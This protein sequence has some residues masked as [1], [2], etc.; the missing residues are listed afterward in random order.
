M[1]Y[2]QPLSTAV[3]PLRVPR[4]LLVEFERLGFSLEA[5]PVSGVKNRLVTHKLCGWRLPL[6]VD[7]SA[8]AL[9]HI[10]ASHVS[11]HEG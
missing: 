4:S 2:P 7:L 10:V 8:N 11:E 9:W 3:G 5:H 6:D 1:P